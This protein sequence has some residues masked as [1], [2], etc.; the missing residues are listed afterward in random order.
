LATAGRPVGVAVAVGLVVRV[1]ELRAEARLAAGSEHAAGTVPARW[2]PGRPGWRDLF[3]AVPDLR[4]RDAGVLVAGFGLAGWCLYL[5]LTFGDP[6]A[7]STVQSA[8][9]W[10][11]G[12]GPRTWLKFDYF[13]T[14]LY[15]SP[16]PFS[17]SALRPSCC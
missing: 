2:W 3:R 14:L 16:D 9:G 13:G 1:I 12:S 7:F 10:N 17:G 8:P 4:W 15:R 6:L 11:Q 5:W